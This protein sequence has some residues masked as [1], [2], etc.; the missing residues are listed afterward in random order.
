MRLYPPGWG[1]LR[2]S[3]SAEPINGY[4]LPGKAMVV[5]CQWVT[6]RHPEFW[7][8][9]DEFRPERFL[10]SAVK[11]QHRFAYF[12]F[13]GGP[14]ICIGLQLAMLEGIL[15]LA[16]I[17]QRFEVE[18]VADQRIMPDATFTLRPKYGL[19]VILHPRA[20]KSS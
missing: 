14:R 1:E 2:E 12:P 15:V 7:E 10:P 9:P 8:A 19:K 3:I 16:T 17:L 13:G 6:H 18:L 4:E 5:L 20:A 11:S